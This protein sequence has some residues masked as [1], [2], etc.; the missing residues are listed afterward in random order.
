M[1][2][3]KKEL[4]LFIVAGEASGDQIGASIVRGIRRKYPGK[5]NIEGGNTVKESSGNIVVMS[6]KCEVVIVDENNRERFRNSVPYGSKILVGDKSK[7]K[8]GDKIAE[9]D[10]YTRPIISEKSGTV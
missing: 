4:K 2:N 1:N 3:N 6:R 7:V 10:P 8:R 5:V 9:W